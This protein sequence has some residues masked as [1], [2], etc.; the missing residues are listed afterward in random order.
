MFETAGVTLTSPAVA[1]LAAFLQRTGNP[2]PLE[3]VVEQAIRFWL[4]FQGDTLRG[5]QW[6]SLFL[7]EGTQLRVCYASQFYVAQVEG[8][9]IVYNGRKV[10]P[11]QF[12]I[13]VMHSVRNAWHEVWLRCPGDGRWHLADAR[14]R[15]LRRYPRLTLPGATPDPDDASPGKLEAPPRYAG[16]PSGRSYLAPLRRALRQIAAVREAREGINRHPYLKRNDLLR[17]DQP[18]LS[19][20][21]AHPRRHV[22]GRPGP[23]ERRAS[24][25]DAGPPDRRQAGLGWASLPVRPFRR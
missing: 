1:A 17:E 10:S 15:L 2:Q 23:P 11:R 20:V 18:D 8:D 14:R 9:A 4:D 6:K 12:V 7:P 21:P 5:Y 3:R 24:V 13:A 22:P 16:K 25:R 19:V